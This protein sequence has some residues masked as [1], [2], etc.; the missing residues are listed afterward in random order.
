[1]QRMQVEASRLQLSSHPEFEPY[2]AF[3]L[4]DTRA[5]GKID[6]YDIVDFLRKNYVSAD[7]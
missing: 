5:A 3:C 1:M 2:K 6:A 7:L 4:L